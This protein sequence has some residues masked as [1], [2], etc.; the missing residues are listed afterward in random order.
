MG[1]E[2]TNLLH[3]MQASPVQGRPGLPTKSSSEAMSY[4]GRHPL[5]PIYDLREGPTEGPT[6]AA[7]LLRLRKG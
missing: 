6:C 3:A 4:I 2:P 5:T 7:D 1:I